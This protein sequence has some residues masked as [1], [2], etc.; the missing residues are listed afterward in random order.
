MSHRNSSINS[1][2]DDD[3][4]YA[5]FSKPGALP[6]PN[7]SLLTSVKK[8][9]ST[10]K[11][12]SKTIKE[13]I[14]AHLGEAVQPPNLNKP[15]LVQA[16]KG[17]L[18]SIGLSN[19][20]LHETK[21]TSDMKAGQGHRVLREL[22]RKDVSH[23]I[24]AE[25]YR[26]YQSEPENLDRMR[27]IIDHEKQRLQQDYRLV[28][29]AVKNV[30]DKFVT[31]VENSLEEQFTHFVRLHEAFRYLVEDSY[32]YD[33][34]L[35]RERFASPLEIMAKHLYTGDGRL[36][37]LKQI[38]NH[39]KHKVEELNA[40][41]FNKYLEEVAV[42]GNKIKTLLMGAAYDS[43]AFTK[44][45]QECVSVIEGQL[46][47]RDG[48]T[49]MIV[50]NLNQEV[51]KMKPSRY[52]KNRD[53]SLDEHEPTFR[54]SFTLENERL[55]K[56]LHTFE[57]KHKAA[58]FGG[59]GQ[60]INAGQELTPDE[61]WHRPNRPEVGRQFLPDRYEAEKAVR[62]STIGKLNAFY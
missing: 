2:Q 9:D 34:V 12:T 61:D 44:V 32:E 29:K 54:Q 20:S 21:H 18:S 39:Y 1:N 6:A 31:H 45:M 40:E 7:T 17:S 23:R 59:Y 3:A 47:N 48:L 27:S 19:I 58:H 38:E 11:N 60:E 41:L 8:V 37:D 24:P 26:L 35:E 55:V 36:N 5:E 43:L 46:S 14:T 22:N 62:G 13:R 16:E 57:V 50:R 30:L 51:Q 52:E 25:L 49:L 53:Y 15:S 28:M 4:I 33:K 10:K 42:Q 56:P